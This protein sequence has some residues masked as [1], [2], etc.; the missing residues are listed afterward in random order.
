MVKS[1]APAAMMNQDLLYGTH[2][3]MIMLW[4]A[5]RF[6]QTYEFKQNSKVHNW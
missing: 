1:A 6:G 3:H 5:K 2:F 4:F